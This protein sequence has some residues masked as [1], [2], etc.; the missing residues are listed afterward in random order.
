MSK[1]ARII[2]LEN[3]EQVLLIKQWNDE[4]EVFEVVLITD[5]EGGQG[6]GTLGFVDESKRDTA[7]DTYTEEAA[8]SFRKTMSEFFD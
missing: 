6:K 5:F 3:D 4:D 2:E 7:F 1:F 8:I